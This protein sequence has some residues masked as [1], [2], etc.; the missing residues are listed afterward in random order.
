MVINNCYI[1]DKVEDIP[2]QLDKLIKTT[3]FNDKKP[4]YIFDIHKTT[5]NKYGELD[6]QI[7]CLIKKLI[8]KKCN[9]YFLSF[10][11]QH[12]RILKNNKLLNS[13][14]IFRSIPKIFMKK[15]RKELILE[16]FYKNIKTTKKIILIDDNIKNIDAVKKLYIKQLISFHYKQNNKIEK[17]Y[18][19]IKIKQTKTLTKKQNKYNKYLQKQI[20]I[21]MS[22]LKKGKYKSKKQAIAIS[23]SQTNNKIPKC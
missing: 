7:Y 20:K 1:I 19:F 10:D 6:K 11:G 5:L 15:R 16:Y 17:L 14:Y 12:A 21:N 2:K 18:D 9:V 8:E 23:Y 22:L 3:T 4:I 13:F